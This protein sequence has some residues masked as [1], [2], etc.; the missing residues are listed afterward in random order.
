MTE[1]ISQGSSTRSTGSSEVRVKCTPSSLTAWKMAEVVF[2][3]P[4]YHM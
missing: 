4:V 3:W 2:V 1:V